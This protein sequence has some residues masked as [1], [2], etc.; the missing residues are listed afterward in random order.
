MR[1][2]GY[3]GDLDKGVTLVPT[4]V[5]D[6]Q[7]L[8]DAVKGYRIQIFFSFEA[9]E[10]TTFLKLATHGMDQYMENTQDLENSDYSRYAI[11]CLPNFTVIPSNKSRVVLLM[12]RWSFPKTGMI[13]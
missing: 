12:A 13:L 8:L 2:F 3:T 11:P 1:Q 5:S 4:P 7:F 6:L 10:D 9:S